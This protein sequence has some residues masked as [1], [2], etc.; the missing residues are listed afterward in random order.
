MAKSTAVET[1]ELPLSIQCEAL[2]ELA[3]RLVDAQV[4][5]SKWQ[6]KMNE[7]HARSLELKDAGL[8][9]A[10]THYRDGV[11]LYLVYPVDA[12]GKRKKVYIGA[13]K[14]KQMT[15]LEGIERAKE[16]DR[17]Q[18]SIKRMEDLLNE[19]GWQMNSVLRYLNNY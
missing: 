18:R 6:N 13:D 2:D 12:S 1:K 3:K 15:A 9:Y 5:V 7:L 11:Y 19:C 8:I 17:V 16:Y 14:R 4:Q 10:G